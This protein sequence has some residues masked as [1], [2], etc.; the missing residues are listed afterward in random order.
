VDRSLLERRIVDRSLLEQWY[1]LIQIGSSVQFIE[2]ED[3]IIW[4]F[5]STGRY[6]AQF[7]ML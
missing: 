1:E 3:A 5:S 4:Q 7:Y 6:F 2:E